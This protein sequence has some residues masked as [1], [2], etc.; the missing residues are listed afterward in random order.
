M[1]EQLLHLWAKTS[2]KIYR[3][4]KFTNKLNYKNLLIIIIKKIEEWR[5]SKDMLL[6][7]SSG[8]FKKDITSL[9]TINN[10]GIKWN[11]DKLI[12]FQET[13]EILTT[14]KR[15]IGLLVKTSTTSTNFKILSTLVKSKKEDNSMTGNQENTE[16]KFKVR[17]LNIHNINHK[18]KLQLSMQKTSDKNKT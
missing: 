4:T 3:N 13:K 8:N 16:V 6:I 5:F 12:R 17:L 18:T 15:D 11:I 10:Q 14:K 2:P 7:T 9:L 1:F